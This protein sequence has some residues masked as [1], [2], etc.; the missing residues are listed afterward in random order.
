M[1]AQSV[2]SRNGEESPLLGKRRSVGSTETL[3]DLTSVNTDVE[4]GDADGREHLGI[5]RGLLI[6]LSLG[7][8]I[9]LQCE[10]LFFN[11]HDFG[12]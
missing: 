6:A 2:R 5:G 9:F 11:Y 12:V 4:N 10:Y 3:T 1:A 7:S 8:L